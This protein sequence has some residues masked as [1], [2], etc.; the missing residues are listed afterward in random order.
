[1]GGF[2]SGRGGVAMLVAAAI[3]A[4]TLAFAQDDDW[5]FGEDAARQL[6]V[7]TV[8]YDGG[9]AVV[10][11]CQAGALK[12]VLVGLPASTE[13]IRMLSASRADGRTDVQTWAAQPGATV[14]TSLV[15]GRDARF[16]RGGGLFEVRTAPGVPAPMRASFDLPT[17]NANLD[18]VLVACGYGVSDERDQLVRAGPDL[19]TEWQAEH[20]D[21]RPNQRQRSRSISGTARRQERPETPPAPRVPT[22]VDISC[23]VRD[24]AY[25]DCRAEHAPTA[26]STRMDER[27]RMITGIKLERTSAAANEGR[28]VYPGSDGVAPLIQVIREELIG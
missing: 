5:E 10:A 15:S 26:I 7:A 3:C 12:V 13:V 14:F 21:D 25:A 28:V 22:P 23:I 11:Q 24:A 18:R 17:E 9:K 20:A 27:I 8:R 4:P 19:K 2:G 1:M 6:T 16:L